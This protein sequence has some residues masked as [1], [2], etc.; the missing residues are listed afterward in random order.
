MALSR[1]RIEPHKRRSI[2]WHRGA[3]ERARRIPAG[4]SAA[5]PARHAAPRP[6]APRPPGLRRLRRAPRIGQRRPR[7]AHRSAPPPPRPPAAPPAP[8]RR[9]PPQRPAPPPQARPRAPPPGVAPHA[10][11][12][13]VSAEPPTAVG[14]AC[15]GWRLSACQAGPVAAQRQE[16]EFE[17]A[18]RTRPARQL[19]GRR[20]GQG[21]RGKDVGGRQCRIALRRTPKAGPRRGDRRRY[22][23]RP[24]QQ[25]NRPGVDRL[26]LGTD[27]RQKPAVLQRCGCAGGP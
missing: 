9:P 17:A 22:R 2:A 3:H 20:T 24:A 14:D 12:P 18:I 4:P 13:P 27:R 10:R 26:V 23:L 1:A 16:A 15:S 11:P 25:P 21:R 8:R 6:P 19:Q 7:R 5:R